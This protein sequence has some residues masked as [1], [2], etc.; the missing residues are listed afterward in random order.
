MNLGRPKDLGKREGILEAAAA[1]FMESGLGSLHMEHVARRANVS[2]ATLYNH[3][4]TK[5]ALFEVLIANKC[6]QHIPTD[7]YSDLNLA[8]PI[9]TL[10]QVGL[11]YL[12]I[13][14]S[15]EAIAMKKALIS[16]DE[17][18]KDLIE[19]FVRNGPQKIL[20]GF[21]E[22]LE[23]LEALPQF[24]FPDKAYA[25]ELFFTLHRTGPFINVLMGFEGP[26]SQEEKQLT[27]ERAVD[28]FVSYFAA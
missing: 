3:F 14:Y 12:E 23:Q 11:N 16:A 7:F 28:V 13:V 20:D 1:I 9:G 27:T 25:C 22:F 21:L 17:M 15:E 24:H 18:S 5:E 26:P 8:D 10:K 19:P 2:K 4:P 6:E